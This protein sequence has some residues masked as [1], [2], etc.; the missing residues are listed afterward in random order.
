MP[1]RYSICGY[2]VEVGVM[3][4]DLDGDSA[5]DTPETAPESD[6]RRHGGEQG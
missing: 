2:V 3:T 4:D 5:G 1:I 6:R